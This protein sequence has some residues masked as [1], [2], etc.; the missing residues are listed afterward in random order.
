MYLWLDRVAEGSQDGIPLVRKATRN[1]RGRHL[2]NVG[3]GI[4]NSPAPPTKRKETPMS[5]E[6]LWLG[7]SICM[8]G[9]FI[10]GVFVIIGVLLLHANQKMYTEYFKDRSIGLRNREVSK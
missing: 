8:F 1:G 7:I 3:K 4:L 2:G 5:K 9:A 6:L 10:S